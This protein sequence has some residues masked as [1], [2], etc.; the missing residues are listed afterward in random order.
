MSLSTGSTLFLLPLRNLFINTWSRRFFPIFKSLK[1]QSESDYVV[2]FA[3]CGPATIKLYCRNKSFCCTVDV[4]PFINPSNIKIFLKKCE[5]SSSR[6]S[7][8]IAVFRHSSCL[9]L[10]RQKHADPKAIRYCRQLIFTY[11]SFM[12]PGNLRLNTLF[13][14]LFS[15]TVSSYKISL[16]TRVKNK[17]KQLEKPPISVK[18]IVIV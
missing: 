3:S 2:V 16:I 14:I 11:P 6:L 18:S 7:R 5:T 15:S 12:E 13:I 8:R 1:S 9:G 4:S 10:R 17:N